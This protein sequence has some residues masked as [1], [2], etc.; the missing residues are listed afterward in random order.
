MDL[1]RQRVKTYVDVLGS[2][3]GEG[4]YSRE[5]I[6]DLLK[7]YF[8]ERDLE[9][10]RGASKPPDIYEKELTSLYI[11]AKY[12]LNILDDY[13]ELLKVFDY[14]VKLERAT[15]SILNEPPEEARENIIKLFPNLDDPTLSRI[16]R[17]GFT[18]MYLDFRDRGFMI[19]LLRNSYAIFPEKADTVRRFAKFF[20][21]AVVA[22]DIQKGRI[23]NSLNKELQ[24]HALSAELGIPKAVPSDEYLVKV[25]QALYGLNLRGIVKVKRKEPNRA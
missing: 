2:V 6:V 16:L 24:K 10:I 8:E 22:D 15:E 23:R 17:F 1:K 18:L 5:Y 4:K 25:A 12:G 19:N 21:A 3:V 7:K 11:I 14:E 13:P 20:I 9:P